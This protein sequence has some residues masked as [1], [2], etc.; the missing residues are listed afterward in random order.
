LEDVFTR[1]FPV[2]FHKFGLHFGTIVVMQFLR[3]YRTVFLAVA[4][5]VV[6]LVGGILVRNLRASTI[7]E[8]SDVYGQLT[9]VPHFTK[10][11]TQVTAGYDTYGVNQSFYNAIDN[12]HNRLFVSD[13]ANHRVLVFNLNPDG[14]P[15]DYFA[16]YVLGHTDF[17]TTVQGSAQNRFNTPLGVA[18]NATDDLLY[19]S[20]SSNNRV[21]VYDVRP[22]GSGSQ[23]LCGVS[24]TG[25][26]N[27][28]NASCV[29]GQPDFATNS[30]SATQNK[31]YVPTSSFYDSGNQRL[32]ISDSFNN[33]VVVY[34]VRPEGSGSQSLCGESTTGIANGMNASCV[35]GQPDFTTVTAGTTQS[36]MRNPWSTV[37]DTANNWLFVSDYNNNRVLLFD[38]RPEGSGSQSLCG[39]STT[40]IANGMNAS[41]VL[42]QTD[43]TTLTLD[44][45]QSKMFRPVGLDIKASANILFV[46]DYGNNRVL[47]FDIRG[48]GSG[49]QDLCGTSTTGIA[50]G[51]NASCV[52]GQSN[53]TANSASAAALSSA[54][55]VT[56]NPSN[57]RLYVSE[58]GNNRVS[59]YN[60]GDL[61]NGMAKED[62]IGQQEV[63]Y[64]YEPP[65]TFTTSAINNN[66][67]I[68]PNSVG[69]RGAKDLAIDTVH[70][71]LFIADTIN[72]RVL[73]F[74]LNTDNTPIDY[75]ADNVIGQPDFA[76]LTPAVTSTGLNFPS[77]MVYDS[78]N[79]RLFVS[80][81]GGTRI[82]V[83][84]TS[85]ITDGMAAI[86]VIGQTTFTSNTNTGT[87]AMN[88]VNTARGLA[89]YESGGSQYLYV[90]DD[91]RIMI[92]DITTL[93]DGPT[94][95][96]VL[97]YFDFGCP[98]M[99]NNTVCNPTGIAIDQ[100]RNLAYVADTDSYRVMVFDIETVDDLE[101]AVYV[102]GQPDF[103]TSNV[104]SI[105]DTAF[106]PS[107]IALN[108]ETQM[109]FV[110]DLNQ[111]RVAV[112][113]VSTITNNEPMIAVFGSSDFTSVV[114]ATSRT[115]LH[116][117][118]GLALDP[119]QHRLYVSDYGGSRVMVY[120]IANLAATVFT[121]AV[122]DTSYVATLDVVH[123]QGTLTYEL[124]SGA[125]PDGLV[126]NADGTISGTP[127]EPG[128]FTFSIRALD[129]VGASLFYTIQQ[130]TIT[131]SGGGG[132]NN[133]CTDP[134]AN[135][136]GGLLPCTY[137]VAG[138][139]VCQN[140]PGDQATV[141]AGLVIDSSGDC[142]T[143]PVVDVCPNIAGAQAAVPAGMQ[144]DSSG[145]CIPTQPP[146]DT[147][148]T[149]PSLCVPPPTCEELGNCAPPPT[150][151]ELGNCPVPPPTCQEL[152][153][154]VPPPTCQELGNCP[155]VPP[156]EP[157]VVVPP[158][159]PGDVSGVGT[160]NPPLITK[161]RA[162]SVAQILAMLGLI[163]GALS[164]IF[165]SP[166]TIGEL[167]LLPMRLWSLLL[168]A[169]G[170]KKR[171]RRWGTVYDAVTKRPLD[172]VYLEL[173]D[174][175]EKVVSTAITDLDGRYGFL[176]PPGMYMLRPHK[177]NYVFPSMSLNRTPKD[178]LYGDLYFGNY[179]AIE[180]EG[181]T[182][183]K[184]IP[185][186]PINFNW[187]EFTKDQKGLLKFYS[188][189]DRL[190]AKLSDIAFIVGFV[191]ASLAL[192][193][194][195]KPYNIVIFC[196]YVVMFIIRSAGIKL[197]SLGNVVKET[198]AQPLSFA[199]VRIYRGTPG[200]EV[201][202]K[203][204]D[205]FGRFYCLVPNGDYYMTIEA[206]ND[207][208]TYTK[209]Y[210][211]ETMHVTNGVIKG[212]WKV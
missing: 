165:A 126:L 109:L 208:K 25:I 142:V 176:V 39:E 63:D 203:V 139:D 122:K 201:V 105:T 184:N 11:F 195:V 118:Q 101:P 167:L 87:H 134:L 6:V 149:N 74:N 88:E 62:V 94:A 86:N 124:F 56:Y 10:S 34:D 91:A 9:A 2:F 93:S 48:E 174:K 168:T 4:F 127:T 50:T 96:H 28:M 187:N 143:I 49:S 73:V 5:L 59:V 29:L 52:I 61:A 116:N 8:A 12:V 46:S 210:Q 110:S 188:K 175:D 21:V 78:S 170:I 198:S 202:H 186:D 119:D 133:T 157:P 23:S 53:F 178:E 183:S 64:T 31:L 177:D 185:M 106:D 44:S 60:I 148:E 99:T 92:F 58:Q 206:K 129:T 76:T 55:G 16:D 67:T 36:V 162:I 117:T 151:E 66:G 161:E 40:G 98:F 158:T 212:R 153:N 14:T 181:D 152:G 150:C 138:T 89:L 32:Y 41:C 18:Y 13:R 35:L 3:N 191:L 123:E 131:V 107:G 115:G 141:P 207:D 135:N 121:N 147:C 83:F 24:T 47:L 205:K 15:V 130:Y 27:G 140:I 125:L 155:I 100:D 197:S 114:N 111:H 81:Q 146:A 190:I 166:F 192:F 79:D 90:A 169:F 204:T 209:V 33:R 69:L 199:I 160:E 171:A 104:P 136:L 42:G 120:E 37:V 156:D 65:A 82:M 145:S 128:D 189:N 211:S 137:P 1:C 7:M 173:V 26:S 70:H 75:V 132:H 57:N 112:F 196:L 180:K 22:A 20:D 68:V 102:L 193:F 30:S 103:D 38:V 95:V 97:S 72:S 84:N 19:V 159:G 144:Q 200:V 108:T 80:D 51:M 54:P 77:G 182:I 71:R 164:S 85:V 194:A 154:C 17:T 172:P 113:D 45:T 43:F 179:F 163:I